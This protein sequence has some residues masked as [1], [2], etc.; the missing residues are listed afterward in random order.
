MRFCML[1]QEIVAPA[2]TVSVERKVQESSMPVSTPSPKQHRNRQAVGLRQPLNRQRVLQAALAV[3][4]REG[5]D[6]LTIRRIGE[7]L[8]VEGMS[9]YKHVDDKDAVLDGIVE[10]LWAE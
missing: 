8:A 10:L 6:Q 9:L 4:D 5:M 1:T 3:V 2:N 7:E